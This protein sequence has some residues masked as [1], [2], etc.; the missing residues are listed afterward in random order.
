MFVPFLIAGLVGYLLGALPF[1]YL[2]A[3]AHGVDI[4]RVGSGN[5]GATN[6]KRV[7]G[8]KAGYTVY[9]L[10]ALKGAAAAAWP[11]AI[12]ALFFATPYTGS[13]WSTFVVAVIGHQNAM[14]LISLVCAVLGHSFSIFTRFKGGKGVATAGGMLIVLYPVIV[15]I[16]AV[17]WFLVA[18]VLKLASVGSLLCAVLFPVLVGVA[19]YGLTETLV[20]SALAVVVIVRHA[21]NLRRLVKGRELSTGPGDPE[22][23]PPG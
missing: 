8:A 21:S 4:F 14:R 11:L 18:R 3:K 15:L 16:L 13:L 9:A 20:I 12:F 5:P 23:D 6:V 19:G 2:V 7:L 1:G 17:V 10:D 22:P